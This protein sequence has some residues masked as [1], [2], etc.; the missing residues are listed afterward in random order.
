MPLERTPGLTSVT[1]LEDFCN[2]DGNQ[3]WYSLTKLWKRALDHVA[4]RLSIM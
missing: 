2:P 3:L 1:L 4:V